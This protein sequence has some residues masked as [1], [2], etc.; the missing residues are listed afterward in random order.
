MTWVVGMMTSE[1]TFMPFIP[2]YA[3]FTQLYTA[4]VLLFLLEWQSM[5]AFEPLN[6]LELSFECPWTKLSVLSN[7]AFIKFKEQKDMKSCESPIKGSQ[8][9]GFQLFITF[10]YLLKGVSS[11]KRNLK[12]QCRQATRAFQF[13]FA[14]FESLWKPKKDRKEHKRKFLFSWWTET[15]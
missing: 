9:V 1:N 12:G 3:L 14:A 8:K 11:Y 13:P 7:T 4:F 10:N 5:L 2:L 6:G 15:G